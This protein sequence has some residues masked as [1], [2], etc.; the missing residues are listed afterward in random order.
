MSKAV[1]S[2]TIPIMVSITITFCIFTIFVTVSAYAEQQQ[3]Q[4]SLQ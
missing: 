1:F 4:D 2:L 3:G